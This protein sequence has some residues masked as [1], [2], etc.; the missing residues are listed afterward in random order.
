MT[1]RQLIDQI[2]DAPENNI[3]MVAADLGLDVP[4]T[5]VMRCI[6]PEEHGRGDQV[7]SMR[8]DEERRKVKCWGCD[9][10]N[11]DAIALV[12]HMRGCSFQ[13]ALQW[14]ADR[15]G[16]EVPVQSA[17]SPAYDKKHPHA[18]RNYGVL[19]SFAQAAEATIDEG[20]LE[21]LATR[22][23]S[24]ETIKKQRLGYVNDYERVCA[25]IAKKHPNISLKDAGITSFYPFAKEGE[26]FVTIPYI[27]VTE[28][29]D[30]KPSWKC[31]CIKARRLADGSPK[32]IAT[33]TQIP[34]L[35]NAHLLNQHEE[36]FI[37]E[38]E[39]DCLTLLSHGFPAVGIPG[40]SGFKEVWAKHFQGKT[41]NIVMDADRKGRQ[42]A[43]D[44]S[45]K[46]AGVASKIKIVRLPDGTDANS[47]F[48][49]GVNRGQ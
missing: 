10:V 3:I 26:P 14:L 15:A 2:L 43:R 23:V 7:P 41:V 24:A 36:I 17:A 33:A 12:R 49:E 34:I 28:K 29:K 13:E 6:F 16:I 42:G 4:D 32:Y 21:Y 11:W 5:K 30:A 46:L 1:D 39:I 20:G 45:R 19:T 31:V 35:Y 25:A 38:G 48:C 44:I 37:C 47:L 8:F 22:G 18:S 9:K 27:G 40:A